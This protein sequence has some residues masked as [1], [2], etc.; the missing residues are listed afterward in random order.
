VGPAI[1]RSGVGPQAPVF[2][3]DSTIVRAHQQAARPQKKG[4][5]KASGRSRGGLSTKIPLL[6]NGL[7]EPVAFRLTGGQAGEFAEALP[8]LAGRRAGIVMATG[9]TTPMP[10]STPSKASVPKPSSH[11]RSAAKC[12]ARTIAPSTSCEI[13]SLLRPDQ[14]T[15]QTRHLILQTPGSP[16]KPPWA[17]PA[18]GYRW[19]DI[20][21]QPRTLPSRYRRRCS[22][23]LSQ[24]PLHRRIGRRFLM[25]S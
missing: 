9:A 11:Q 18:L 17:S 23:S 13:T 19:S 1:R 14:A 2:D 4:K 12:S 7:G 15:S 21:I 5:N 3:L 10:S 24:G 22:V 6:A 16:S 8:L 20:S 25:R